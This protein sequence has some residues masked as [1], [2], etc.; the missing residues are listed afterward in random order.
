MSDKVV[1]CNIC[2]EEMPRQPKCR[3]IGIPFTK[4]EI[5]II[6]WG[7]GEFFCDCCSIEREDRKYQGA[8]EVG[9]QEG[10]DAGYKDGLNS[11]EQY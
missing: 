5:Q 9:G 11:R 4:I 8:Y 3:N 2:G 7:K 6:W 1:I 10:Y